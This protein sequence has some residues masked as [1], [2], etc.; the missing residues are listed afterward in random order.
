MEATS[1]YV[2]LS[3]PFQAVSAR[4]FLRFSPAVSLG[5][6]PEQGKLLGTAEAGLGAR[7]SGLSRAKSVQQPGH[8][9]QESGTWEG[10][11]NDRAQ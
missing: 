6:F 10:K 3:M 2:S 4:L 1:V 9:H 11:Q 5:S 7:G 8:P